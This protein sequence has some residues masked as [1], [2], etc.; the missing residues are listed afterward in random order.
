[1]LKDGMTILFQGDSITDAGRREE[2]DGLGRG[3]PRKV[4]EYLDT[5]CASRNITVINRGIS[6]NRAKD[7]KARWQEDCI[8]LK[9]DI[10][11]ILIGINDT[12]RKYDSSDPTS[13]ESYEADYRAILTQA[14]EKLSCQ[15]VILEPFVVPSD[16]N[17]LCWYEDLMPKILVARKLAR[18]FDAIYIP[19]DGIFA[20]HSSHNNGI[21]PAFWSED[22]VHP[23][24]A[25]H[26]LMARYWLDAML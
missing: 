21:A 12:W 2:P 18:E 17:K 5:F 1:M 26:A 14:R 22:G 3:Y 7:L 25:G 15:I 19:F 24:D 16:E 6:G 13:V 8:D 23:S 20:A 10:L 9:P 4:K 11:S